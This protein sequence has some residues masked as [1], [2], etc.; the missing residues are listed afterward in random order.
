[1]EGLKRERKERGAVN[2]GEEGGEG[3]GGGGGE[4]GK[5]GKSAKRWRET[6]KERQREEKGEGR[7]RP[8]FSLLH[9]HTSKFWRWL[10]WMALLV[11]ARTLSTALNPS[12]TYTHTQRRQTDIKARQSGDSTKP[13]LGS[14]IP[15]KSSSN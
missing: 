7:G 10:K 6:Q 5:V 14:A 8:N 1:M 4:R 3:G 12:C 11:S 13:G 2:E 15:K 9:I